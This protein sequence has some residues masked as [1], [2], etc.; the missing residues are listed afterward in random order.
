MEVSFTQ[1]LYIYKYY[2]TSDGLYGLWYQTRHVKGA[3][4]VLSGFYFMLY[5]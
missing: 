1:H 3:L 5:L 2:P 4:W